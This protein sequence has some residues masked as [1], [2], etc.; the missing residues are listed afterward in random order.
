MRRFVVVLGLVLAAV[1]GCE[2]DSSGGHSGDVKASDANPVQTCD[3]GEPG[4]ACYTYWTC[5]NNITHE[6]KGYCTTNADCDPG[7]TCSKRT[8]ITAPDT[9]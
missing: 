9:M 8:W 2:A 4:L 5:D 3:A 7:W 1:A 6:G